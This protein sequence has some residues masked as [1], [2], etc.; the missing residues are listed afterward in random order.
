MPDSRALVATVQGTALLEWCLARV[1]LHSVE[2]PHHSRMDFVSL[3]SRCGSDG[4][5][6]NG[7]FTLPVNDFD[8]ATSA[9]IVSLVYYIRIIHR[10]LSKKIVA[11]YIGFCTA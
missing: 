9:A 6:T 3:R 8:D 4:Y 10:S 5:T 2:T 11:V 1:S 7:A